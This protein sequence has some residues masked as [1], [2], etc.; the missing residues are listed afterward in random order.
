M[1]DECPTC[2][3]RQLELEK[4]KNLFR[5]MKKRKMP[6]CPFPILDLINYYLYPERFTAEQAAEFEAYVAQ[7]PRRQEE[8]ARIMTNADFL[9]GQHTNLGNV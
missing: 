9:R 2:A 6:D 5:D 4:Q 3:A 8:R 7:H 1:S